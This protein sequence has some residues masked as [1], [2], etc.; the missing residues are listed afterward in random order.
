MKEE[1][2]CK[3]LMKVL[4]TNWSYFICVDCGKSYFSY[5]YADVVWR[6]YDHYTAEEFLNNKEQIIEKVRKEFRI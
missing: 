2:E 4:A 3:R 5:G 6:W 1:C